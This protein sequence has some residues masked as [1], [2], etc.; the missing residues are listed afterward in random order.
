LRFLL[1]IVDAL[2]SVVLG[3]IYALIDAVLVTNSSFHW[4]EKFLV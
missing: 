4:L 2:I 3:E 1:V